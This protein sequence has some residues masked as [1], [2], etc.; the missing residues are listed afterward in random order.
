[1][2]NFN[3][4]QGDNKTIKECFNKSRQNPWSKNSGDQ[5]IQHLDSLKEGAHSKRDVDEQMFENQQ[6]T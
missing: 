4:K 3:S 5:F 6:H 1:M 2:D